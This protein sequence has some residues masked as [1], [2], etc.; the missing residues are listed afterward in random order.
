MLRLDC[1]NQDKNEMKKKLCLI[2]LLEWNE[3][4]LIVPNV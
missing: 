1:T 2:G 3:L 4:F